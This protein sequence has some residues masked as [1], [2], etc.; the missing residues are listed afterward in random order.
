MRKREPGE[1]QKR[2]VTCPRSH[3]HSW[4]RAEAVPHICPHPVLISFLQSPAFPVVVPNH[5]EDSSPPPMTNP[6]PLTLSSPKVKDG[7]SLPAWTSESDIL[8]W[9]P[10]LA[11]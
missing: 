1:A 8:P 9:N 5:N 2:E 6:H 3:G 11:T 10:C 4:Q 7:R